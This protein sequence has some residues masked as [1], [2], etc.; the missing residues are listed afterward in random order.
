MIKEA[1]ILRK[2]K[3]WTGRRHS[4]IIHTMIKCGETSVKGTQGFVTDDGKFVDRQE[5]FE[6]AFACNQ[7]KKGIIKFPNRELTSEDLY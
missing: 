2:G 5:A 6:I 7:I 3:I 1:A 4:D